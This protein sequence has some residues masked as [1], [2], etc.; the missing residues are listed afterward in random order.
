MKVGIINTSTSGTDYLDHKY[1]LKTARMR[2]VMGDKTYLDFVEMKADEFFNTIAEDRSILPSTSTPNYVE[3]QELISEFEQDGYDEVLI[4]TVSSELSASYQI[5]VNAAEEY[6]GKIKVR[7]YDSKTVALPEGLLTI[8]ACKLAEEGK[9]TKEIIERLD[10]LQDNYR[11]FFVVDSLRLLIK[12]GRLSNAS[13]FIGTALKIKP[14]LEISK[15]GKV[16]TM[17]KVRTAKK[18]LETMYETFIEEVK[19][20]DDYKIMIHTSNNPEVEKEIVDFVKKNYPDKETFVTPITPVVGC[21]TDIKIVAL[22][23]MKK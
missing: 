4:I 5:A 1:N 6:E 8:E 22:G 14:I 19:D 18:A 23:Y 13:G 10:Y 3:F 11:V 17:L 9:S 2:V 20:L 7:A 12:N 15:E 16:E 21:H